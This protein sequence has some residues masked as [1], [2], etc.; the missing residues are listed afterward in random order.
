VSTATLP[1]RTSS[2]RTPGTGRRRPTLPG[3]GALSLAS[4][5]VLV[6]WIAYL[7][8]SLPTSY[9]LT[10]WSSAWV[11][12][13]VLLTVVLAATGLLARGRHPLWPAAAFASAALLV[14]DA[15]FDVMTSGSAG[16]LV[17]VLSAALLELPLAALLVHH[18][19]RAQT[20]APAP[21][22]ATPAAA[23]RDHAA[24]P[25]EGAAVEG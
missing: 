15:W 13:D 2:P 16:L 11:G 19:V 10:G 8:T 24:A 3:V 23:V 6:P 9:V 21:L 20:A 25:Q 17:P 7:A 5:V 18:A 1:L 14:A 22:G 4:A 12:F